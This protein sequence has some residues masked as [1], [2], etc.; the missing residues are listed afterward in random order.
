VFV[1]TWPEVAAVNKG[2]E[3]CGVEYK[4]GSFPFKALG[5]AR[6]GGDLDSCKIL[7]DAKQMKF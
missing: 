6:A 4:A 1:Y 2:S 7:A 5:R 3:S